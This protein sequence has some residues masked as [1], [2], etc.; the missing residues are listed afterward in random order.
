MKYDP[1]HMKK[2]W[3]R[4]LGDEAGISA[5]Q[6]SLIAIMCSIAIIAGLYGVRGNLND[7]MGNVSTNLQS[8]NG[9][10]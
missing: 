5:I 3:L 7:N 10:N 4:F 6:Y 8:A 9:A 2:L 1:V